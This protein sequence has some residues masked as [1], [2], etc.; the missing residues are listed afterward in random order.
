[1]LTS[2]VLASIAAGGLIVMSAPLAFQGLLDLRYPR[3]R[4]GAYYGPV[5]LLRLLDADGKPKLSRRGNETATG[6]E[7]T[8]DPQGWHAQAPEASIW[9]QEAC[10]RSPA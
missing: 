1:M 7:T 4:E 8:S 9:R 6:P 2:F 5:H 3:L 10:G